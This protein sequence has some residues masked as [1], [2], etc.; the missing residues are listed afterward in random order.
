MIRALGPEILRLGSPI[1]EV[2]KGM[3]INKDGLVR[4]VIAY[5]WA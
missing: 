3:S 2:G 4:T 1:S 5:G